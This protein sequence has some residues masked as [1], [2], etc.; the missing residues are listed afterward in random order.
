MFTPFSLNYFDFSVREK[1][2]Q[3]D[4]IKY[5]E[6]TKKKRL[7]SNNLKQNFSSFSG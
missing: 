7:T 4:E 2:V 6:R 3:K 5:L 1:E